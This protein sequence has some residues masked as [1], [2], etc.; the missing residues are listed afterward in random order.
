MTGFSQQEI[1]IKAGILFCEIKSLNH[2]YLDV[3]IRLPELIKNK[4]IEIRE[5]IQQQLNRGKIEIALKWQPNENQNDFFVNKELAQNL[6]AVL[7]EVQEIFSTSQL[8]INAMDLLTWEGVLQQKKI[9]VEEELDVATKELVIL[10]LQNL[11]EVREREGKILAEYLQERIC[12]LASWSETVR[13]KVKASEQHQRAL[14]KKKLTEMELEFDDAKFAHEMIW[15]LQKMD[16]DEELSRLQ[17]HFNEIGI[18]L[19]N[20]GVVGRKLDFYMQEL[21]RETNTIASKAMDV[22]ISQ[23]T[24]EMKVLIE[25]MREQVQNIE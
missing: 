16:I 12:Q 19:K 22:E 4:E 24:V 11:V 9:V 17:A 5:W 13:K 2:R 21:N 15:L 8:S 1:V 10:T 23:A 6:S 25:Q 3:S 7:A 18:I 14:I 20:G